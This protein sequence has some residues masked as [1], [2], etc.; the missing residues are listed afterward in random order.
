[1]PSVIERQV[2]QNRVSALNEVSEALNALHAASEERNR[3]LKD[4]GK[5]LVDLKEEVRRIRR[6][7]N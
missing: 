3:L 1:M 5:T 4:L 2:E 6:R 7:T